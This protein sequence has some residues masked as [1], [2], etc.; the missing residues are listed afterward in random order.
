MDE[1]SK[2]NST[3]VTN[4][5]VNNHFSLLEINHFNLI[6]R[7]NIVNNTVKLIQMDKIVQMSVASQLISDTSATSLM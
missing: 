4:S 5:D 3:E 1:A 2:Y 6:T 7:E